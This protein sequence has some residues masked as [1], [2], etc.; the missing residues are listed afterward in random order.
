MKKSIRNQGII[1]FSEEDEQERLQ[2]LHSLQLVD[3]E[4]EESFDQITRLVADIFQVPIC[5]VSL[6]TEDRQW[7]KSCVGVDFRETGREVAFCQYVVATRETMVVEDTL[8][9]D[10]FRTNRLVIEEGIR[11]YAGAKLMTKKGNILGTLCIIDNQPRV[12]SAEERTK[13]ENLAEWVLTEIELREA[14]R[15]QKQ[16]HEALQKDIKWAG[17]LQQQLL[18][19]DF[20]NEYIKMKSLYLPSELVSGDFYDYKWITEDRMFGYLVDVMGHGVPTALQTSAI[21]VLFAQALDENTASLG[22][23]ISSINRASMPF[24]P[25]GYYFTAFC[26]EFNFK[27]KKLAYACGGIN[28]FFSSTLA[29]G[30]KEHLV[31]GTLLGMFHQASFDEHRVDFIKGDQ[32][33]FSTDGFTD[34][35]SSDEVWPKGLRKP[36]EVVLKTNKEKLLS[37]A[38]KDDATALFIEIM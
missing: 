3:T 26:F 23:L 17:D 38:R 7:F 9:D 35:L 6:V 25:E 29:S 8:I 15:V 33:I 22:D 4:A 24:M 1:M 37:K 31:P 34:L 32:F 21:R 5:L 36:V 11:F 16:K 28:R 19:D 2:E 13:L 20:T 27:D 10:R 12:F 14:I 18:P 30:Q